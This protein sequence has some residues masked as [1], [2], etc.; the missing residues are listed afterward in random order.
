MIVFKSFLRICWKKRWIILLAL[1]IFIGVSIMSSS[2]S[3]Q[4]E[5]MDKAL[6]IGISDNSKSELSN[7]LIKYLDTTHDITLED[8]SS[9]EFER[10]I[11]MISMI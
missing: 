6:R 5:Y 8:K 2:V 7:D 4:G 3:T 9:E 1:G 10:D 11:L